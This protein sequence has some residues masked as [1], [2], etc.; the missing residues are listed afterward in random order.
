MVKLGVCNIDTRF[1]KNER[2]YLLKVAGSETLDAIV[3][4]ESFMAGVKEEG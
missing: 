1:S 2:K 3:K 4:L